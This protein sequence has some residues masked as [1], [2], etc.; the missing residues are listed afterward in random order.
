M[1]TLFMCLKQN[2]NN[3]GREMRKRNRKILSI[4]GLIV[5][6]FI[7]GMIYIKWISPTRIGFINYPDY[8]FADFD[9]ANDNSFIK[10]ERID[11][12]KNEKAELGNYAAVYIFGMGLRLPPE[13]IQALQKAVKNGLAVYVNAATSKENNITSI[14]GKEL[15]Y[16]QKCLDNRSK[17]NFERLLNFTRRVIDGKKLFSETVKEPVSIPHDGF[18]HVGENALF[19]TLAEYQKYRVQKGLDYAKRPK[20][21]FLT[22]TAGPSSKHITD[23]VQA[24]EDVKIN[25]YPIFGFRKRLEFIR[26]VSPDMVVLMPHGR[27][28]TN[29]ENEVINYLKKRNIPLI[30]PINVYEPHSKWLKDQRGMAGGI[31]SQ[32][33]TMPEIDGGIMPFV[34]SAQFKNEKGLYVFKA[35]PKRLKRFVSTVANY[36]KL[37]RKG[38]KHKKL[39]VI[40]YKG[41]GKN[42]LTAAGLEV[43]PSL[44]NT[45]KKLHG[46]GYDTGELPASA[47]EL[48]KQIQENASVFNPYAKGGIEKFVS[49]PSRILVPVTDYLGWVKDA[50]PAELYAEVEQRYG[51]A[52][53]PYMSIRKN[54]VDNIVLSGLRFGNIVLMPQSLPAYGDD[55][56]KLIH[57]S[58]QAPPHPYIATY[59]WAK[60][61]FETDAIMHFGTHGS[62]EFTPWKQVAL[63]S[64]DWADVLIGDMPHFYIYTIN[65]IGE[66]VIAK[67]RGYA[68]LISHLTPPFMSS[69]LY[70]DLAVIHDKIHSCMNAGDNKLLRSEY[71]K[72]ILE[73]V[74]K[75]KINRELGLNNLEDLD[76]DSLSKLHNYI[77]ELES[78]KINRGLYVFN[79]KYSDKEADETARLMA[80]DAIAVSLADIDILKNKLSQEKKADA[81]YF[82][83]NYLQPAHK[84]IDRLLTGEK[85]TQFFSSED[86][87]MLKA[88]K[89]VASGDSSMN[90]MAMMIGMQANADE[91]RKS[92]SQNSGFSSD[93]REQLKQ[94]LLKNCKVSGNIEFIR[95]LENPKTFERVSSLTSP[96][97]FSKAKRIAQLI[98]QMKKTID[99]AAAPDMASLIKLIQNPALKT[100]LFELLKDKEIKTKILAEQKA[101]FESKVQMAL[102]K[103]YVQSLFLILQPNELE[104]FLN[105]SSINSMDLLKDKIRKLKDFQKHLLFYKEMREHSK[106]IAKLRDKSAENVARILETSTGSLD[107]A[108]KKGKQAVGQASRRYA[109]YLYALKNAFEAMRNVS[110]YKQAL[111][112]STSS[113]MTSVENAL[114]GGYIA[115]SAGADPIRNPNSIPTGRNMFSIDAESTPTKEAWETAVKL[116]DELIKT[117]LKNKGE[118]PRKVAFSLWGGEFIRSHGTNVAEILYML[119]VK[120]VWSSRG[121]VKDVRLI[122]IDELKRPRID[123]LVQTSGQ[124]RGA[125]TSRLYL[126][127]KAVRLASSA[128]DGDKYVNNVQQGTFDAERVMIAKGYSPLEARKLGTARIFGGIDGRFGTGI[129]GL[130]ESG[131]KWDDDQVLADQY[132]RNMGAIYTRDNW[133]EYKSGVFEAAM[134]NTDTVVQP[135]SSNTWGPLSLD[136]VYEFMGGMNLAVKKVTGNNPQT[137]FNDLRNP[138]SARIQSAK[139]AAMV[140]ARTTVLNP[141]YIKEMMQEGASAAESFAEIA[142]NSYGWEVMRPEMLEDYYWKDLKNTIVDDK[143]KLGT[144]KFFEQKN[145]YALQEMTAVMLETIRKGYWKA[146]AETQKQLAKVH[147]ELVK[148]YDAGCSGF[149]CDNKKLS[150][151]ID[152]LAED[153]ELRQSYMEKIKKVREA[154]ASSKENIKGME[155]KKVKPQKKTVNELLKENTAALITIGIVIIIFIISVIFGI[156]NK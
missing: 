48:E 65:N 59:L 27:F 11:W 60:Y 105:T 142:R 25:I 125:A 39:V 107:K 87:A 140:E 35:L 49:A 147:M 36:L 22:S 146:D 13:R 18:F 16:V 145:P 95:S 119:G 64:Y 77:H 99:I 115:P 148:K 106:Y 62:F 124:F 113:E 82:D 57:G 151:M 72:S 150:Q 23:I 100:Y 134:Q 68:A 45:L 8:M 69:G 63:S 79:R 136:H 46:A 52:P 126:I 121:R 32:S 56:N 144:R 156:K 89:R 41:P 9:S 55:A 112:S 54:G 34:L 154:P 86:L 58:K 141:E 17:T 61:G 97:N 131:D 4:A 78:A 3:P 6:A 118:Y 91:A 92:K 74:K 153:M 12:K 73:L 149:V 110:L 37:Q 130:V 98:P 129:M 15:D 88:A 90:L 139:E 109:D 66:A 75:K 137:F 76:E 96:R 80:V 135:R 42:A 44:F 114:N 10:V 31:M 51:A 67:R 33:V 29:K 81:H 94:L 83:K 152:G 70:D 38:N 155:L 53:G 138:N 28:T 127:D 19:E 7:V 21:C 104:K 43:V 85:A 122:P 47:D 20:I 102:D 1:E 30:C 133:C 24:L 50:M 120:P 26:M 108:L 2:E 132:M 123:V 5:L 111:L 117:T 101:H 40:Y 116:G 71:R 128:D 103:D 84:I 93:D 143:Y 14:A